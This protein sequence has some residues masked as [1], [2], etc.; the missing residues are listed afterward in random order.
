METNLSAHARGRT[1]PIRRKGGRVQVK[2][3]T[4]WCQLQSPPG[5]GPSGDCP[6]GA[7]HWNCRLVRGKERE[8]CT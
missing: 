3:T 6:I 4:V 8:G 5:R 2:T 7:Q 1:N